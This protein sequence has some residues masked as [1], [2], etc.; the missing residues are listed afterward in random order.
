MK[1]GNGIKSTSIHFKSE[2]TYAQFK[3]ACSMNHKKIGDVIDELLEGYVKK[4]F[5]KGVSQQK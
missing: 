5:G 2:E 1:K 4:T 3:A